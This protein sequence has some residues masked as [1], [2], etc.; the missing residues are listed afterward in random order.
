MG[1]DVTQSIQDEEKSVFTIKTN[2]P[3]PMLVYGD[4]FQWAK[5]GHHIL[6]PCIDLKKHNNVGLH[7][8]FWNSLI[9]FLRTDL[10][11][12]LSSTLN[13]L[14]ASRLDQYLSSLQ[15]GLSETAN[16]GRIF[17]QHLLNEKTKNT[18]LTR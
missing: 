8:T 10:D 14:T 15:E 18:S 13:P 2:M 6:L 12:N 11:G 7:Q 5:H 3:I 1:F 4:S 16:K 9:E 17:D